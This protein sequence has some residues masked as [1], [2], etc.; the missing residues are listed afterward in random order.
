V[1]KIII[2]PKLHLL[3]LLGLSCKKSRC[4]FGGQNKKLWEPF[5]EHEIRRIAGNWFSS[6]VGHILPKTLLSGTNPMAL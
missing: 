1:G 3:D 6:C 4:N 5:L 2:P